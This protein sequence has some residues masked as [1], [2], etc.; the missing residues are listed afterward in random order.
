[1]TTTQRHE[2]EAWLGDDHGLTD[3]QVGDLL[4]TS[5]EIAAR[6]PDPDDRDEREAAL[7]VAYRLMAE[8]PETVVRE[9]AAERLRAQ[10]AE[11]RAVAGLRQ[12]AL[13]LVDLDG[14]RS[15]RGI[16]TQQGFAER[17]GATRMT[18]REW[19]GLRDR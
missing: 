13:I 12:A 2:I 19:L 8:D 1:M 9:V 18:V 7:T 16:Q 5:D 15:A 3:E 11:A 17:A 14:G 6:Y 10:L 4:R